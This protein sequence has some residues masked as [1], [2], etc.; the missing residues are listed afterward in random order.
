MIQQPTPAQPVGRGS[1]WEPMI[2]WFCTFPY[3]ETGKDVLPQSAPTH[4]AVMSAGFG[5]T[6]SGPGRY[7]PS[8]LQNQVEYARAHGLKLT[9]I[10]ETG[11]VHAS[12]WLRDQAKERGESA[13]GPDGKPVPEPTLSSPALFDAQEEAITKG[14]AQ[15]RDLGGTDIVT[16]VY[17]G[18]E[19]WFPHIWRYH[20]LEIA[21]FRQWLRGRYAGI[22]LLNRAWRTRFSRWEDV[23][24]PRLTAAGAGRGL[25][26]M[27]TLLE[28]D[29]GAAECSWSNAGDAQT[30]GRIP[31][32][33]GRTYYM[34]VWARQ[35]MT[36]GPGARL[37]VAWQTDPD[38][39]PIS[40]EQAAP[41]Q[42]S[43]DWVLI[44]ATVKAPPQA[45][46]AWVLLKLVGNGTIWFDDVVFRLADGGDNLAGNAGFS[47]G[48]ETPVGWSFQRWT[49]DDTV[50]A[51]VDRHAGRGGGPCVRIDAPRSQGSGEDSAAMAADWLQFWMDEGARYIDA[52]ASRYKKAYPEMPL[53]SYLTFAFAAPAEWDDTQNIAVAPDEVAAQGKHLDIFGLQICSADRDALRV[54]VA[55][56]IVRK[57]GKP[58]WAVDLVDFTSGVHIGFPDVERVAQSA[59][60][61]GATGIVYCSWHI[62]LVLDY[63]YH[64]YIAVDDLATMNR[65]AE[66]SVRWMQDMRP[67]PDGAIVMPFIP[68][69]PV[70]RGMRNDVRSFMGWYRIL[71][72][73]HRTVDV[74]TLNELQKGRV[75]LRRYPWVVVP[76]CASLGQKALEGLM[77]YQRSGGVLISSG[78]FGVW[79]EARRAIKANPPR[80]HLPDYGQRYTGVPIRDT[81]AGNTPPLFLWPSDTPQRAAALSAARTALTR[82]WSGDGGDMRLA[83]AAASRVRCMRWK[84]AA[85]RAAWLVNTGPAD[86][87][88]GTLNLHITGRSSGGVRALVDGR[89]QALQSQRT[90]TGR[91]V[92][93]PAFRSACIIR[94]DETGK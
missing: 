38:K 14:L 72:R 77:A 85:G 6:S 78:R 19:W 7:D 58:V 24:P 34:S 64:P 21:R 80:R 35:K 8:P 55:E 32:E 49:G 9:V 53:A 37:E 36:A 1:L 18:A 2:A 12:P 62:N 59:L 48:G 75:D 71:E 47:E 28:I 70:D 11:P 66:K 79:D 29:R 20:P 87:K 52:L 73:L 88:A 83:G 90:R 31:I 46:L 41:R 91:L 94:F 23:Q 92:S 81:H 67:A 13:L 27:S 22:G 86:V 10:S 4:L 68:A 84:G 57:Y 5:V 45:K 33:G 17:P 60:Q 44:E 50:R 93:V 69:A 89:E 56:D 63:S 76:D 42:Q 54:T 39:P 15:I 3:E 26:D 16:A 30:P 82:L 74:V 61:H 40:L 43:A 65:N 51:T 25:P